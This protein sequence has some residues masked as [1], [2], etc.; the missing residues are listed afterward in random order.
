MPPCKKRQWSKKATITPVGSFGQCRKMG[1]KKP[2]QL[3]YSTPMQTDS[4]QM[5]IQQMLTTTPPA[6]SNN[7]VIRIAV[8]YYGIDARIQPL[9][10]ERDQNFRLETDDARRFV[11]KISNH[12][13]Q[14]K[15]IDFQN[16]ALLHIAEKD[17]SFPLP[18][19][20]PTLDEQLHCTVKSGGKT[21]FVR[22]LSWLEGVA[23]GKATTDRALAN[24]L[25]QLLAR[26]GLALQGFDHPG[27][28]PPSLWDMKR[29]GG[30]RELLTYIQD[31]GLRPFISQA[32]D[33]FDTKVKPA[34]DLLRSQVIHNDMNPDNVLVARNQPECINGVIDFGDMV[35]SPLIIDLAIA[36]A[37]QLSDGE[38]PL[39]GALPMITGYHT[40]RPLQDLEMELL[41][42]LIKTRLVTSLLIN[43]YRVTL[44]PKNREYLMTS[45]NSARNFLIKLEQQSADEALR[46]IRAACV[47]A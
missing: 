21:H 27:S 20:I 4:A 39:N 11:C 26:L 28:S 30:L 18:R 24:R 12:A 16:R 15:V 3:I 8:K 1:V 9:V 7:D 47:S 42:D 40:I 23:L 44:F 38:S 34:L 36:A 35:K 43:S 14:L 32:L 25:G 46:Q 37:Y 17:A 13:E 22:V 29:A 33:G 5:K 2:P 41:M 10:S 19:V 45:Y 31:P 6:L